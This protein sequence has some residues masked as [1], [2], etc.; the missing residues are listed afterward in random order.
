MSPGS[1]AINFASVT[2]L[3]AN[4]PNK[5]MSL[6]PEFKEPPESIYVVTSGSQMHEE[7]WRRSIQK[8]S[9]CITCF[10]I[11]PPDKLSSYLL[12]R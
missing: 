6:K 2:T 11:K 9:L 5:A 1:A 3:A 12:P 7:P 10:G 8:Q 4:M